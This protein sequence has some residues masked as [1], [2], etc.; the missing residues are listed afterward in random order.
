MKIYVTNTYIQIIYIIRKYEPD[1]IRFTTM[2]EYET[3]E[4]QLM[5]TLTRVN[6][7]RVNNLNSPLFFSKHNVFN[8]IY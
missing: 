4:K 2:E 5:D 6:Q 8:N 3:C 7:R 1:P